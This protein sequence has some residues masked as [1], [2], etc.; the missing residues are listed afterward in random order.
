[1]PRPHVI[2][3]IDSLDPLGGASVACVRLAGT[4]QR[5]GVQTTILHAHPP[6]GAS[7]ADGC[8]VPCV[9]I[10]APR[11]DLPAEI[12]A[13]ASEPGSAVLHLHGVWDAILA[14]AAAWARR[15]GV[16][17]VLTPH[18]MLSCWPMARRPFRKRL[19]L[20]TRGGRLLRSTAAVHLTAETERD[21]AS[22]W[23]P[24]PKTWVA[25]LVNDL[26]FYHAAAEEAEAAGRKSTRCVLSGLAPNLPAGVPVALFLSRLNP[27][28]GPDRAIETLGLLPGVHLLVAG[29]D[30]P[31]YRRELVSLAASVGVKDRV[32]WLGS[33]SEAEKAQL[34]AGCDLFLL[35]T[36][37]E[38]F[39]QVLVE[40]MAC[41][42]PVVT[43]RGTDIWAELREGGALISD[44]TAQ[45]LARAAQTLL[46]DPAAARR[47]ATD[48]RVWVREWLDPARTV[49]PYLRLYE[50][51]A[52]GEP[53]PPGSQ[54]LS[55][56][57]PA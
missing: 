47:R 54:G 33:V 42:C 17:A 15:A 22:R 43:T 37:Q 2:H 30:D 28:K 1:M 6:G 35:P 46:D 23:V 31:A 16:P 40:A 5:V 44:P 45:S 7:L 8:G 52:V 48:G 56:S 27:K 3:V 11:R 18:G 57:P 24:R 4:L 19:Y 13:L 55:A 12:S 14:P 34:Y 21:E 38:N 29:K 32:H 20:L 41:G 50:A 25:S 26:R 51:L 53:L 9:R 36:H 10:A 39:G 49:E